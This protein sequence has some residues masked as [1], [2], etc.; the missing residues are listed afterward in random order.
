MS[1]CKAKELFDNADAWRELEA[2]VIAPLVAGRDPSEP[3]RVWSAVCGGGE[4][5]CCLAILLQESIERANSGASFQI[6]ATDDA[7]DSPKASAAFYPARA[8]RGVSAERKSKWFDKDDQGFDKGGPGWRLKHSLR[9][10]MVFSQRDPVT[11]PGFHNIDVAVSRHLADV[12]F[13]EQAVVFAHLQAALRPGGALF[14]DPKVAPQSLGFEPVAAGA[15]LFR[16]TGEARL[17]PASAG[18]RPQRQPVSVP[19]CDWKTE[20]LSQLERLQDII[21]ELQTSR[22]ELFALNRELTDVNLRLNEASKDREARIR[23]LEIQRNMLA[24]GE[25]AALFLDH[26]L[27]IQ[28]FTSAAM[29]LFPVTER[30]RGR[31]LSDFTPGFDDP[32]FF[33]A[34]RRAMATGRVQAGEMRAASGRWYA[35]TIRRYEQD[36][37]AAKG[38]AVTFADITAQKQSAEAVRDYAERLQLALAVGELATWDWNMRGGAVAWSDEH[39]EMQGYA[40]GEIEP[41]YEAWAAR[42]HPDDLAGAEAALGAAR[43]GHASFDHD[44]RSLHP[45]GSIHWLSARGNFFYDED[46]AP[47]RMIGVMRD[48]TAQRRAREELLLLN[49]ELKRRVRQEVEAREKAMEQLAQAGK[50][51]ALGELAGGVAHD[52][53]NTLQA[54]ATSAEVM[55]RR[56]HDDETVRRAANLQIKAT[57]RGAAVTRR[58]LAFRAGPTCIRS[59]SRSPPCSRACANC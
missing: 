48:I 25:V 1:A 4:D 23:Q 12:H 44:F 16:K 52:F 13:S 19:G 50:L 26:D 56:P 18:G 7:C 59:R 36:A 29:E 8:M 43:D 54:I 3:V 38:L 35:R 57:E 2:R 32:T 22:E 10:R 15:G 6:F 20:G 21:E 55:R 47:C 5:A 27:R 24:G 49:S 53:N 34:L 45:D 30:D 31:R 33:D 14:L 37:T 11:D 39:F 58:L 9:S 40:I 42:V 46:G 28:W 41:S 51:A 17:A